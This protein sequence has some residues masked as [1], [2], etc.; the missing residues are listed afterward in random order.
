MFDISFE[1]FIS[2]DEGRLE[3]ASYLWKSSRVNNF[4]NRFFKAS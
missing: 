3:I 1:G 4:S 2:P